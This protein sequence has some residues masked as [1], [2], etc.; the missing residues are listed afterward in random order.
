MDWLFK[1][2]PWKRGR[3][4]SPYLNVLF[5]TMTS[6]HRTI[7]YERTC[8]TLWATT[9]LIVHVS[10]QHSVCQS[11]D[12]PV[13]GLSR[14]SNHKNQSGRWQ[15][16]QGDDPTFCFLSKF[17]NLQTSKAGCP[18]YKERLSRSLVGEFN[19]A[20][21]KA[22]KGECSNSS[23]HNWLKQHRPKH[24]ICP[25]QQDYCD[26]CAQHS[27]NIKAKQTTWTDCSKLQ[28]L[29]LKSWNNWVMRSKSWNK[30]MR[31]IAKKLMTCMTTTVKQRKNAQQNGTE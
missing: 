16:F 24:I 10:E 13:K 15:N 14:G 27:A 3:I 18:Q 1:A 11:R 5:P 26:T 4:P 19:R 31:Y 8:L 7:G 28:L 2:Q 25:H 6:I 29:N 23:C 12:F 20:Q 22:G 21:R 30:L 17:S 9:S